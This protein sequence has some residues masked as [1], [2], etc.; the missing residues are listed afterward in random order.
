M[1][2]LRAPQSRPVVVLQRPPLGAEV[3]EYMDGRGPDITSVWWMPRAWPSSWGAVVWMSRPLP[4]VCHFWAALKE[5][6]DSTMT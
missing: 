3:A 4:V 2:A 5:M 1:S 6:S